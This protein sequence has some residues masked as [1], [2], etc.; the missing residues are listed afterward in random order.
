MQKT[1]KISI[2]FLLAFISMFF[3][4]YSIE[5]A[6]V[7]TAQNLLDEVES[8]IDNENIG[9]EN[10]YEPNSYNEFLDQVNDLGGVVQIQAVIDDVNSTQ[11]DI[12]NLALDLQAALDVLVLQVTY[13][14]I[15]TL[16][17]NAVNDDVSDYTPNSVAVY[18]LDLSSIETIL[19]NP[20]TS[21]AETLALEQDIADAK[22]NLVLQADK[23]NLTSL[24]YQAIIAYYEQKSDYT[25]TSYQAFKDRVDSYGNYLFVNSVIADDNVSQEIVDDLETEIAD[26]LDLLVLR[27]DNSDLLSLYELLIEKDLEAYTSNSQAEYLQELDCIYQLINS[28]DLDQLLYSTLL[29]DL[30]DVEDLL[31]SKA[32]YINLQELYDDSNDYNQSDYSIS[33]YAY[34]DYA[35]NNAYNILNNDNATQSEVD[36]AYE[37][38]EDAVDKLK[39]PNKTIYLKVDETL[40]IKEYLVMGYTAVERYS[41]NNSDATSIDNNGIVKG[42][43]Y[44]ET[45]VEILFSNGQ[46]ETIMLKVQTKVS[47]T[48]LV[49]VTSIPV[50]VG[51]FAYSVIFVKKDD[52]VKVVKNITK[53]FHKK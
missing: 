12:D 24:N 43:A 41:I 31:I 9:P 13:D 2:I 32:D 17:N 44:G 18:V 42:L 25:E 16:Y 33:S 27:V 28:K 52:L 35:L 46:I 21:E 8:A 19:N 14:Y 11:I 34:L 48:T 36:F 3:V 15:L 6:D 49:L 29:D 47:T 22:A 50:V 5:A 1:K 4:I 53:L 10:Y 37:L 40:D 26:A 45:E 7:Q 38:L 39:S 51:L 20:L 23:S 30:N